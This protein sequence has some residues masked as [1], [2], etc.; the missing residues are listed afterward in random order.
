[1]KSLKQLIEKISSLIKIPEMSLFQIIETLK[2]NGI[3]SCDPKLLSIIIEHKLQLVQLFCNL[4]ITFFCSIGRSTA[5]KLGGKTI[6]I[7]CQIGTRYWQMHPVG[8]VFS[9]ATSKHGKSYSDKKLRHG[10]FTYY[11]AKGLLEEDKNKDGAVE[12]SELKSYLDEAKRQQDAL[13]TAIRSQCS[14]QKKTIWGG[15][16]RRDY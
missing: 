12:V 14:G 7:Y 8:D 1:M 5:G 4:H 13:V 11:V 3:S 6:I 2:N 9:V 10:I 15:K 16:R